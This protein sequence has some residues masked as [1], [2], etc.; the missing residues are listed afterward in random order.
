MLLNVVISRE[1]DKDGL[2]Q[3]ALDNGKAGITDVDVAEFIAAADDDEE[4]DE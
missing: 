4:D 1:A 3:A 2:V